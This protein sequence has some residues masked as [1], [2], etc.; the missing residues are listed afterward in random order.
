MKLGLALTFLL[1]LGRSVLAMNGETMEMVANRNG[2]SCL[3]ANFY[4]H[5][6]VIGEEFL[7]LNFDIIL[8]GT[9]ND[10]VDM[11]CVTEVDADQFHPATSRTITVPVSE[12]AHQ[13][14][15]FVGF[16]G[17]VPLNTGDYIGKLTLSCSFIPLRSESSDLLAVVY[18]SFRG[19]R[20]G[21]VSTKT[22]TINPFN[23]FADNFAVSLASS[24]NSPHPTTFTITEPLVSGTRISIR[25]TTLST[26]ATD[27]VFNTVKTVAYCDGIYDGRENPVSVVAAVLPDGK[28]LTLKFGDPLKSFSE[29]IVTCPELIGVKTKPQHPAVL[30]AVNQQNPDYANYVVTK[31]AGE[32]VSFSNL[33]AFI[34]ET[35]PEILF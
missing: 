35:S 11:K 6:V 15:G 16:S 13:T 29:I 1:A 8:S 19:L 28:T 26:T 27:V 14:A 33:F 4:D 32:D 30:V 25:S 21:V 2:G 23:G 34:L 12:Y 7:T 31:T 17:S 9:L 20:Q 22:A 5:V 10:Y 3:N 24:F 18:G